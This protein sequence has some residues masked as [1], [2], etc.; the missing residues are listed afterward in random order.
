MSI[1]G[2]S[3]SVS[4]RARYRTLPLAALY[5]ACALSYTRASA[6]AKAVA[7][8]AEYPIAGVRDLLNALMSED[9]K[10]RKAADAIIDRAAPEMVIDLMRYGHRPSQQEMARR[11]VVRMGRKTVP[12]LMNLL[13]DKEYARHAGSVLFMVIE[14]SDADRIPELI[15]CAQAIPEAKGYCAQ[16]IVKVSG[17]K[18]AAHV[19]ALAK[20]LEASDPLVRVHAAV[21]LGRV[22]KGAAS[23]RPALT[24]LLNDASPDVRAQAKTALKRVGG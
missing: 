3:A 10:A 19:P 2:W 18:A 5:L 20:A 16:S 24:K 9:P 12:T 6:P 22:G 15:A 7:A 23:A 8:D 21:A 11:V 13:G 17:P 14:P 4:A 1:F